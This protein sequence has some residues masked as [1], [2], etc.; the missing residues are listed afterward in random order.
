LIGFG[1]AIDL[2]G[3][4]KCFPDSMPDTPY[5][6]CFYWV[7]GRLVKFGYLSIEQEKVQFNFHRR[8]ESEYNASA[9]YDYMVKL[10]ES[11][12][13]CSS[14]M[15]E[16]VRFTSSES[17]GIQAAGLLARETMKD[18]ENQVGPVA[19]IRRMSMQTLISTMRFGFDWYTQDYFEDFLK[20]MDVLAVDSGIDS[21]RMLRWFAA[22][23][24][25]DNHANRLSYL[26]DVETRRRLQD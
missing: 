6:K 24:L 15:F 14:F 2:A 16:K 8:R 17:P 19:R 23:R 13:K 12:W 26:I 5:Y 4:W 9:L 25:Q 18:F 10:P 1:A 20:K 3:F 21:E 22:R 11:E 7:V